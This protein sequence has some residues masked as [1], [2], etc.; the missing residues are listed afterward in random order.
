MTFERLSQQRTQLY[1]QTALKTY[2]YQ[3]LLSEQINEIRATIYFRTPH[4]HSI[5]FRNHLGVRHIS[6]I[7]TD[8]ADMN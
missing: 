4:S 6:L 7:T 5:Y 1:F 3:A 8:Y 2:L